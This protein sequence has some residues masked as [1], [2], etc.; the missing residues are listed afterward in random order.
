M[1]YM[2]WTEAILME[3]NWGFSSKFHELGILRNQIMMD[4]Q[5]IYIDD[6]QW[7]IC[8]DFSFKKNCYF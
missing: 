1:K 5:A 8:H 6:G 4:V 2:S 3:V 7:N